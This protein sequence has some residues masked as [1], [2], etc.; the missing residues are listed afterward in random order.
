M[1]K[2]ANTMARIIKKIEDKAIRRYGFEDARTIAI[3]K[4]TDIMRKMFG[5]EMDF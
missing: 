5:V 3:F 4:A 1:P 2:G